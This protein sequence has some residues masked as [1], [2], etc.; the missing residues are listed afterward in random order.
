[1][2]G[3]TANAATVSAG[4]RLTLSGGTLGGVMVQSGGTVAVAGTG[5]AFISG[6]KL[7]SGAA[8]LVMSGATI[9]GQTVGSGAK[10][11]V[12]ASGQATDIKLF[13]GTETVASGGVIGGSVIFGSN[14]TLIL[15]AGSGLAVTVSGFKPTDTIDLKNFKFSGAETLTYVANGANTSGTLTVASGTATATIT[16]FGQ[17]VAAGF[18]KINDGA[19]GT[20]ITYSSSGAGTSAVVA[21]GN[22]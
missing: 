7:S 16:L 12:Y 10:L 22:A 4:G 19:G 11:S 1:V 2:I 6:L 9:S 20:A 21:G 18:H 8:E 3:G 17:Y 15:G 13:A 14:A 5:T